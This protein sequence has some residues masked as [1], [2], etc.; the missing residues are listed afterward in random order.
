MTSP[1][2]TDAIQAE[3]NRL[4]KIKDGLIQMHDQLPDGDPALV[5]VRRSMEQVNKEIRR[6]EKMFGLLVDDSV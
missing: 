3:Y 4:A 2:L 6:V 1:V 5:P